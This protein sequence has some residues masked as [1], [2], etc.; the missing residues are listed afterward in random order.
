MSKTTV[1]TPSQQVFDFKAIDDKITIR[2]GTFPWSNFIPED[3]IVSGIIPATPRF[4]SISGCPLPIT[5]ET[6]ITTTSGK[7]PIGVEE[8]NCRYEVN[9]ARSGVVPVCLDQSSTRANCTVVQALRNSASTWA[10][11]L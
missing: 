11:P 3:E 4:L 2:L 10:I 8:F 1:F 9:S 7:F 6:V 5:T